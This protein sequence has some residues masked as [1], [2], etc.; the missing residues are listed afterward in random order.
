MIS[1]YAPHIQPIIL[2]VVINGPRIQTS[3]QMPWGMNGVDLEN[4]A[5]RLNHS[6]NVVIQSVP[7]HPRVKAALVPIWEASGSPSRGP[8]FLNKHG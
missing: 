6:K 2:M 7:L 3:L 1:S 5:M 4:E 8:V